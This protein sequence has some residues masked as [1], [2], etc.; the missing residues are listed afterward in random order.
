MRVDGERRSG[1]SPG[2]NSPPPAGAVRGAADCR[3]HDQDRRADRGR[4]SP[5]HVARR[6]RL[7]RPSD[8]RARCHSPLSSARRGRPLR[9]A[10]ARRVRAHSASPAV[11][12]R[13]LGAGLSRLERRRVARRADGRRSGARRRRR[14]RTRVAA[15][16]VL[17]ARRREPRRAGRA[18]SPP[19][20]AMAGSFATDSARG[21][22]TTSFLASRTRSLPAPTRIRL[23]TTGKST[24]PHAFYTDIQR[25]AWRA[26]GGAIDDYVQYS[27]DDNSSHAIRVARNVLR[28]RRHRPARAARATESVRRVDLRRRRASRR[29]CPCSSRRTVSR[30]IRARCSPTASSITTSRG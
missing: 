21:S 6:D 8:D 12:R 2:P 26:L 3:R 19:I 14:D 20:G 23:A 30:R 25:I 10:A 1:T 13:G 29:T 27:N 18:T 5:R 24:S 17:P 16:S 28:R 11:H 15:D 4:A 9:R 22:S 7:G